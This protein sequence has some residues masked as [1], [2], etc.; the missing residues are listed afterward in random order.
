[1]HKIYNIIVGQTNRQLQE[2]AE[3]DAPLQEIKIGRYPIGYPIIPKKL[4]LSNK[5]KQHPIHSLWLAMRWLYNKI[6]HTN[7]KRK[8]CLLR[9]HNSQ[10]VT[11]ACNGSLITRGFQEHGMKIINPIH[12]TG[13]YTLSDYDKK[14]VETAG[15]EILCAVLYLENS[16]KRYWEFALPPWACHNSTQQ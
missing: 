14:E 6:H 15:K 12:S 1:M 2:K 13:F 3:S 16:D 11:E 9:L 10:K 8:N 5:Y 4:C 7:D